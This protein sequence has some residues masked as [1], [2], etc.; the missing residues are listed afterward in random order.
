M[1]NFRHWCASFPFVS[2][3]HCIISVTVCNSEVTVV[4]CSTA[5]GRTPSKP[6]S[7]IADVNSVGFCSELRH[8]CRHLLAGDTPLLFAA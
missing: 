5:T 7:L 8:C 6:C 1:T 4:Y 2:F 3:M